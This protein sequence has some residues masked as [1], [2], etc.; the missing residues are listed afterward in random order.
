MIGYFF[1]RKQSLDGF[2]EEMGAVRAFVS[3]SFD[4]QNPPGALFMNEE[5][6]SGVMI[7]EF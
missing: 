5:G 4:D 3:F 1:F 6:S 7:V 2:P